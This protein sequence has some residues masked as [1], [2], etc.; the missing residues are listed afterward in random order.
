MN[1]KQ[2]HIIIKALDYVIESRYTYLEQNDGY[3]SIQ[4]KSDYK[5]EIKEYEYLKINIECEIGNRIIAKQMG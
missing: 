5:S 3:L 2:L 4:E 1:D